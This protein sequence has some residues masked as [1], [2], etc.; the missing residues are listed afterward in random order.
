MNATNMLNFADIKLGEFLS[1]SSQIIKRNALSI[2]KQLQKETVEE[3]D[4]CQQCG[5]ERCIIIRFQKVPL[6]EN[7][8]QCKYHWKR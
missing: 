8:P 2:L 5:Y 4:F 7:C 3:E 1:S 6:E